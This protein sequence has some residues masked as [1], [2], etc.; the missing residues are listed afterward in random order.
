MVPPFLLQADCAVG[1]FP[2]PGGVVGVTFGWA[3]AGCATMQL[4]IPPDAARQ[5][6]G[7]LVAAADKADSPLISGDDALKLFGNMRSPR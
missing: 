1:L 7:E 5:L 3:L 6:A 2:M 4:V